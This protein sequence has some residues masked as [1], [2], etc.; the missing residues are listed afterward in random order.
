MKMGH[1]TTQAYRKAWFDQKWQELFDE[2]GGECTL[3]PAKT[4]L[5]FAHLEPTGLQGRGRGKMKRYYDIK[6]NPKKYAL[7]C[8]G[9]H[10]KFDWGADDEDPF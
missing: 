10:S 7:L 1:K 8:A 2:H 6:K 3:C 4:D 9:C 5:E